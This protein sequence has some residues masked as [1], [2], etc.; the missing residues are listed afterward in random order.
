MFCRMSDNR[1]LSDASVMMRSGLW[2]SG[3]GSPQKYRSL[4]ITSYLE[5]TLGMTYRCGCSAR[6][7]AEVVSVNSLLAP[8]PYRA[9]WKA[10]TVL[11]DLG[12]NL[13]PGTCSWSN[14]SNSFEPVL[15]IC[16]TNMSALEERF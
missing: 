8:C 14:I 1:N 5:H 4:L 2:L 3:E 16:K 15:P 11:M 7:L 6:Y 9:R 10:V 12:F 13:S